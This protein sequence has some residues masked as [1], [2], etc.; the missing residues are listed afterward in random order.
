[1]CLIPPTTC[2]QWP[3]ARQD[4]TFSSLENLL[5]SPSPYPG[6]MWTSFQIHDSSPRSSQSVHFNHSVLS[7]VT[8]CPVDLLGKRTEWVSPAHNVLELST[9]KQDTKAEQLGRSLTAGK[10]PHRHRRNSP[11]VG[12]ACSLISTW[13]CNCPGTVG[14]RTLRYKRRFSQC[15]SG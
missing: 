3:K 9:M 7:P 2:Q 11:K 13:P 14:S 5:A 6:N 8:S 10:E 1:M 12:M 15:S 4:E